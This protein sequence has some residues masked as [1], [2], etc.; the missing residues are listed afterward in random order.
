MRKPRN[1]PVSDLVQH[2]NLAVQLQ[3]MAI[4]LKFRIKQVEGLYY[5]CREKKGADQLR[6]YCKADL[7]LCFR[8]S[9]TL[10]FHD[11]A[12]MVCLSFVH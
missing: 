6:G 4:G 5:L 3:K 2:T 12:L 9:K 10:V 1:V 7:R 11:A 8:I